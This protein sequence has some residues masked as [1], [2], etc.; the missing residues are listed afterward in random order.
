MY[1]MYSL[2]GAV[3]CGFECVC[4]GGGDFI[5][6]VLLEKVIIVPDC[7]APNTTENVLKRTMAVWQFQ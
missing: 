6:M 5:S 4:K 3:Q 1:C 2:N 7:S